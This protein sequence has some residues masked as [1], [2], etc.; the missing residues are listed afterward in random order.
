MQS[1]K[2]INRRTPP[3]VTNFG[4]G[5]TFQSEYI[6]RFFV[7]AWYVFDLL[8][9]LNNLLYTM[10]LLTSSMCASDGDITKAESSCLKGWAFWSTWSH[11]RLLHFMCCSHCFQTRCPYF[12]FS[13]LIYAVNFTAALLQNRVDFKEPYLPKEKPHESI[14]LAMF[15]T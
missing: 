14:L 9:I 1:R 6:G 4:Q 12:F 15:T 11:Y 2:G 13:Y 7:H 3:A 5:L 8:Y 10:Q